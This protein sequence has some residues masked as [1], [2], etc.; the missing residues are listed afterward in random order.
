[1]I[2]WH[3]PGSDDAVVDAGVGQLGAGLTDQLTAVHKDQDAPAA[4]G[5]GLGD[6]GQDVGLAGAGRGHQQR[7]LGT[8]AIGHPQ[9]A[10]GLLLVGAEV[11]TESAALR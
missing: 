9:I 11:Q 3:E 10:D 6:G 8:A 4:G 1:M 7:R 5:S 2:R